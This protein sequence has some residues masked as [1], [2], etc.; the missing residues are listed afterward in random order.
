[1][2]SSTRSIEIPLDIVFYT[3]SFLVNAQ[4]G[5]Y[6]PHNTIIMDSRMESYWAF[7]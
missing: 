6:A 2:I 3:S 5:R 4:N 1:M 7:C